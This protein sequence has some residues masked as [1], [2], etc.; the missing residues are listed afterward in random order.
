MRSYTL[1]EDL[2]IFYARK[3][4][5]LFYID[6]SKRNTVIFTDNLEL[7]HFHAL[8]TMIPKY[9]PELFKDN[10]L[11]EFEITLLK[12]LG[13]KSAV[14]YE[15]LIDEFAKDIDIR[16]EIIRTKLAGFETAFERVRIDELKSEITGY[17]KIYDKHLSDMRDLDRA[18]QEHKYTL[19]GLVCAVSQPDGDS[20]LMEYFM[21]NK[22]LTIMNVAQTSI[23]FVVNGYADVYDEEA[24]G[25][26]VQ[27]HSGF[28][29]S[30]VNPEIT[31][32]QMESLYR[33]IFGECL[34]KLRLCAAYRA[35]MRSGLKAI[36]GYVFPPE[37][38]DYFPNPHIQ[39]HACI[40]SYAARFQE[41]MRNKDY[42]GAID[43]AVVSA[44][45]LNFYDSPVISGLARDL[46]F[47]PI[48]C[49]E[50]PDGE[51]LTP[52]EAISELEGGA[53]CRDQ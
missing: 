15:T 29:Y 24:F 34:Y 7:K 3:L 49:I 14:E 9:L 4:N 38:R 45:N 35:D 53:V 20:E 19:S 5:A 37:S 25:K 42:V 6:E 46:S 2:R 27:N 47:S 30:Q 8:Q 48:K 16:A 18:I 40:G 22:S 31:K 12:S 26:Y 32:S 50:K 10:S 33:A 39:K 41:Y 13:N 23:E 36:S 52:I 1:Q 11:T 28:M 43:Q 17:Q 44:R 51:L 21:C